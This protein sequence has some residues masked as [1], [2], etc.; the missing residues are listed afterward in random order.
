MKLLTKY[1]LDNRNYSFIEEVLAFFMVSAVSVSFFLAVCFQS[2]LTA[3]FYLGMTHYYSNNL[4]LQNLPGVYVIV[5]YGLLY[6]LGY[7][8]V[9]QEKGNIW[10]IGLNVAAALPLFLGICVDILVNWIIAYELT[11][12]SSWVGIHSIG[13]WFGL[14]FH[15][16]LAK[17]MFVVMVFIF[18]SIQ[19]M[20]K[21]VPVKKEKATSGSLGSAKEADTMY[22]LKQDLVLPAHAEH[23]AI[24]HI[25]GRLSGRYVGLQNLDKYRHTLLV[26]AMRSGKA[27]SIVIPRILDTMHNTF[28][29]D[30][31]SELFQ[32]TYQESIRKGKVPC[33]I[34]PYNV[35]GQYGDF[36]EYRM[37]FYD[38]INPFNIDLKDP[39]KKDQYVDAMVE[40]LTVETQ[41][42][43]DHFRDAAMAILGAVIYGYV[44]T[45]KTLVDLHDTYAPL[46][47]EQTM[48]QLEDLHK[49]TQSRRAMSAIG[50]LGKVGDKEAGSMLSTLYR[51]FDYV[52]TDVWAKFFSKTGLD[53]NNCITENYDFYFIIPTSQLK[54][55]PK[56]VRLMLNMFMV[57]FELA[58]QRKLAN[59]KYEVILDEVAQL[60]AT[61]EIET[62]MEVYGE[63]GV[64]LTLVF[65]NLS[66]I[67]K[68]KKADLIK[69]M[70]VIHAFG[71][72]DL[73]TIDWIQKMGGK[74]TI[75]NTSK[76]VSS[77]RSK[78]TAQFFAAAN[79][80]A[81]SSESE[82]EIATDLYHS[83]V[84]RELSSN[85][86][87]VFIKGVR[88]FVCE[89]V[90][91]YSDER[92][93]GRFGVNYV[94]FKDQIKLPKVAQAKVLETV[95]TKSKESA[96]TK[97]KPS[98]I[99]KTA[100]KTTKKTA[101]SKKSTAKKPAA[102]KTSAVGASKIVQK[103]TKNMYKDYTL[104]EAIII[105]K[106][107]A[108]NKTLKK[109]LL[110]QHKL[111][112]HKYREARNAVLENKDRS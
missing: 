76:S 46:D 56:A 36:E 65:Q 64:C 77:S 68:F 9:N 103:T 92:Y 95:S 11:D 6:W 30:I 78:N 41:F 23:A 105:Y 69:G 107:G 58:D 22:L 43:H 79:H 91:Y 70:D 85:N 49:F 109:D 12:S 97:D 37:P 59:R 98:A 48:E 45:G 17:Y 10:L 18:A 2:V 96:D 57:H 8:R 19:L 24:G 32:T 14:Y 16:D 31:K 34:D 54:R 66:Q 27:V 73:K 20:T 26:A 71:A 7:K 112:P 38:P 4:W 84:I 51:S 47:K 89:R 67:E 25:I 50:L 61:R 33:A 53:M 62:L 35:L 15:A 80:S 104:E 82:H 42:D 87:F 44:G 100:P 3:L 99:K 21:K 29:L 60:S 94:E 111:S 81:S 108:K 74:S 1:G 5:L 101:T 86:Q 88:P 28:I 39:T 75:M 110:I 72:N 83:N 40:A 93:K 106:Q 52:A 55:Y 63:K 90:R 13:Q 102:K